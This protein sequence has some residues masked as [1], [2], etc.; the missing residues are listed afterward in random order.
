MGLL[1]PPH[2]FTAFGADV[3][4]CLTRHPCINTALGHFLKVADNI[5]VVTYAVNYMDLAEIF[6]SL[7][8]E[9]TAFITT[10]NA[11]LSGTCAKTCCTLHTITSDF[12]RK[13]T[14][15]VIGITGAGTAEKTADSCAFFI[16]NTHEKTSLT[17]VKLCCLHYI[18]CLNE[19]QGIL[20]RKKPSPFGLSFLVRERRLELP[21]QL[22]H[23]PQTCL[24]TGSS[25]LAYYAGAPAPFK[26]VCTKMARHI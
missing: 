7:A 3:F 14:V 6:N 26:T 15:T 11:V 8:G 5:L 1:V 24:S 13:A 2:Q 4:F 21:R 25:T 18:P 10:G 22:T 19:E 17:I 23:A 16:G 12:V 20:K 9:R